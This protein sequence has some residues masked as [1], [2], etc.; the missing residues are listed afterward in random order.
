MTRNA[1]GERALE[2]AARSRPPSAL[3]KRLP[4]QCSETP[5]IGKVRPPV[6]P[7]NDRMVMVMVGPY[8]KTTNSAKNAVSSQ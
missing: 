7:W 2:R 8:R 1:E 5:R 6:G 3:A 4:N